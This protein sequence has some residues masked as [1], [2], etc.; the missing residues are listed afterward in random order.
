MWY[1]SVDMQNHI[2]NSTV[3]L[4]QRQSSPWTQTGDLVTVVTAQQNAQVNKLVEENGRRRFV[5]FLQRG[6][7]HYDAFIIIM[8]YFQRCVEKIQP[9]LL[10]TNLEF[11]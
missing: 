10:V 8:I 9:H 5:V 3:L 4:D 6:V 11:L 1:L 2:L 7:M